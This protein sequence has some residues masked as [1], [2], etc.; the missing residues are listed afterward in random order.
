MKEELIAICS[1][2]LVSVAGCAVNIVS[3]ARDDQYSDDVS[4]IVAGRMNYVI[5]GKVMTPYGAFRPAWP[6]PFMNAVNLETGEVHAFPAVANVDGHFA[7][8]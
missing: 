6:A 1:A 7:G 2:M 3:S 4:T 8:A 5:D